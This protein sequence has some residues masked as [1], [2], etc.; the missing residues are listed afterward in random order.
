[1]TSKD[2]QN[3][4]ISLPRVNIVHT[5]L[6]CMALDLCY[7][8]GVPQVPGSGRRLF[9]AGSTNA[10]VSSGKAVLSL[11]RNVIVFDDLIGH[12]GIWE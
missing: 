11:L 7:I 6:W 1:M 4:V 12:S 8:C 5:Y 9:V 2:I 3:H 10:S